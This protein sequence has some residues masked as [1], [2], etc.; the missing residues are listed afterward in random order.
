MR[1]LLLGAPGAGK[2]SQ[3]KKLVEKYNVPQI[4]TGDLLRAAVAEGTPLGLQAKEIIN[5]GQLVS[6]DI[7]LG[8]IKDRL[9]QDDTTHGFILDGFPRN[10]HQAEALDTLLGE[11]NSPLEASIL[12][13]VDNE[14]LI[15]RIVNR[16]SCGH[17]GQ[18]FNLISSPPQHSH[19]CDTCGGPLTHRDD[20][21]EN[22]V[23]DRL[24][25]Y[26][27]QTA[28]LVDYYEKQ[29]KLVKIDGM[30]EIDDIFNSLLNVVKKYQHG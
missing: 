25:V 8:M 29:N 22:T 27:K 30:G 18:M 23:R 5:A 17:C 21:N 13:D 12:L 1:I 15:E 28:P 24:D 11:L 9:S 2:G 6:D 10:L 16:E 14:K 19:I 3:A 20:D 7:V 26:T 4:S